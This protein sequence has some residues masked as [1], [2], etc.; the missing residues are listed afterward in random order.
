MT[1]VIELALGRVGIFPE[2]KSP[3]VYET[4]GFEMERLLLAE[5]GRHGLDQPGAIPATP[6]IIQSFSAES[7]RILRQD[8]GTDLPLTFL[9]S[10]GQSSEWLTEDGLRRAREFATGIGPSKGLLLDDPTAVRRAHA[11]GMTVVPYTFSA[12]NPGSF[13]DVAAEMNHYLHEMGVDG[14]FTNNPDL[15]P[16]TPLAPGR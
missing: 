12:S 10:G 13:P 5:L 4:G 8:L 1:E 9:L 16:R 2:T 14:L 15:F 6:V 7:L 3:E 11:L